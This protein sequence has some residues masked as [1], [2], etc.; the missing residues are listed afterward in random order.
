MSSPSPSNTEGIAS[1][2]S[3]STPT[4]PAEPPSPEQYVCRT[5]HSNLPTLCI[6]KPSSLSPQRAS[7]QTCYWQAQRQMVC[8]VLF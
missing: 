8:I 1:P 7:L 3:A 2:Q 6:L 5:P 4:I